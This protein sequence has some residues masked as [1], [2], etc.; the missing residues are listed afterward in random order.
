MA[1]Q[2]LILYH[3][4]MKTLPQVTID[5]LFVTALDTIEFALRLETERKMVKWGWL[6]KTYNQWHALAFLLSELTRRT[7]GPLVQR[8]WRAVNSTLTEFQEQYHESKRG[9]LWRPVV[10]LLHTA[11]QA[12][13]RELA[14]EAQNLQSSFAKDSTDPCASLQSATDNGGTM[15]LESIG[16]QTSG[17]IPQMD[18]IKISMPPAYNVD[19]NSNLTLPMLEPTISQQS[20]PIDD[21]YLF[22]NTSNSVPVT[23]QFFANTPGAWQAEGTGMPGQGVAGDWFGNWAMENNVATAPDF[24]SSTLNSFAM[25][26]QSFGQDPMVSGSDSSGMQ[27]TD[28]DEVMV[29][30]EWTSMA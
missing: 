6:F 21:K 18:D 7:K 10:K 27:Y 25:N 23:S 26:Q 4:H 12:R 24:D 28:W 17:S 3:P 5:R 14:L 30:V 8:A 20:N 2:F 29:C 19:A 9:Q 15:P 13:E 1:R 22:D 16:P 11:R